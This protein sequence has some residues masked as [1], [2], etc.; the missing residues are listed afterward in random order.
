[1]GAVNKH[2]E[3]LPVTLEYVFNYACRNLALRRPCARI[4]YLVTSCIGNV[5]ME[6]NSVPISMTLV[7]HSVR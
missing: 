2:P 5:R 6:D 1:M 4:D 7:G 3:A